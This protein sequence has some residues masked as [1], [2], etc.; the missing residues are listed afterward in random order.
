MTLVF[1]SRLCTGCQAC[2][3]ACLDQKD[4]RPAQGEGFLCRIEALETPAQISFRFLCCTHCGRCIALCPTGSLRREQGLVL[5]DPEKCTGCGACVPAC[6]LGVL[7]LRAG[8]PAEKCD[9]CLGRV[10][11]GLLPACVHT[12]PTGALH[13]EKE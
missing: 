13:L 6:P 7:T 1:D 8:G 11:A 12:C 4:I 2:Q 3:M 10:Q 5:P 9:L